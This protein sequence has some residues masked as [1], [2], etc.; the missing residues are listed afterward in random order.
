MSLPLQ[1]VIVCVCCLL[2]LVP[3]CAS[4]VSAT[5][6][7]FT[8]AETA[9]TDAVFATSLIPPGT[10]VS[11]VAADLTIACD[12][13][14]A[15]L[16]VLEDLVLAVEDAQADAGTDVVGPYVPSPLVVRKRAAHAARSI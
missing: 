14:D 12:F 10:P 4:W 15:A 3:A 1:T 5:K 2:S 11:L 16:P 13:A 8:V 9:C 6:A 7:A